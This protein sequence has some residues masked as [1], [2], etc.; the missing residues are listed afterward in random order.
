MAETGLLLQ[1]QFASPEAICAVAAQLGL[2]LDDPTALRFLS[3]ARLL[4]T[5]PLPTGYKH[6]LQYDKGAQT[7]QSMFIDKR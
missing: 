1:P 7:H 5:L 4:L 3:V 2:D 6:A